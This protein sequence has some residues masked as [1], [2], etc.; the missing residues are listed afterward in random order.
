FGPALSGGSVDNRQANFITVNS[1]VR[2]MM[3]GFEVNLATDLG[4]AAIQNNNGKVRL[5]NMSF[6]GNGGNVVTQTGGSASPVTTNSTATDNGY[7]NGR[8]VSKGGGAVTLNNVTFADAPGGGPQVDG[9]YVVRNSVMSFP[10]A[11]DCFG[12]PGLGSTSNFATDSSCGVS[13]AVGN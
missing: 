9:P 13:A 10:S 4:F 11:P 7:T 12:N 2:L 3:A 6:I 1:G 5:D 8:V